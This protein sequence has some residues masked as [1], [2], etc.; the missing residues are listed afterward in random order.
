M[1]KILLV[2]S[3]NLLIFSKIASMDP[4]V[5]RV[6]KALDNGTLQCS[7]DYR[8]IYTRLPSEYQRKLCGNCGRWWQ[9]RLDWGSCFWNDPDP[10]NRCRKNPSNCYYKGCEIC[11]KGTQTPGGYKF[12]DM[13]Y[14]KPKG[15]SQQETCNCVN[16]YRDHANMCSK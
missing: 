10:K 12:P 3:V 15:G 4:E 13:C 6:K 16:F 11:V 8:S 9:T 14:S 7:G 5:E 1:K 2:L